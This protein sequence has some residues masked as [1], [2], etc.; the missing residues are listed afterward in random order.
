MNDLVSLLV[1][2]RGGLRNP[3][4]YK[5][6]SKCHQEK[7]KDE[8]HCRTLVNGIRSP[9]AWCKECTKI[10]KREIRAAKLRSSSV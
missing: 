4:D 8:F 6:C 9:L 1:S 10:Y 2:M 7:H 3:D 5:E